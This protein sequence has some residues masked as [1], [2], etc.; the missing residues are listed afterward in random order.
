MAAGLVT[1]V[2]A[3]G[4]VAAS[5]TAA[6]AAPPPPAAGVDPGVVAGTAIGVNIFYTAGNGTV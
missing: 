5:V 2:A 6:S 1:S 3:I 4:L